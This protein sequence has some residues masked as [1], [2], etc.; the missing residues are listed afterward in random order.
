MRTHSF[1]QAA[2]ISTLLTSGLIQMDGSTARAADNKDF[3]E[4]SSRARLSSAPDSAKSSQ[5]ERY[6]LDHPNR[7]ERKISI[8]SEQME[9]RRQQGR[10]A[11]KAS[12]FRYDDLKTFSGERKGPSVG[13][14]GFSHSRGAM[15]YIEQAM[16]LLR[17][18]F[19][20][21]S[22]T[23]FQSLQSGLSQKISQRKAVL[24]ALDQVRIGFGE[25]VFAFGPNG[26]FEKLMADYRRTKEGSYIVLQQYLLDT[27]NAEG[28]TS[29]PQAIARIILHEISHLFDVG[30]QDDQQSFLFSTRFIHVPD[31]NTALAAT[32]LSVNEDG[33]IDCTL[34]SAPCQI[35]MHDAL[36]V[37][38]P[39]ED[40]PFEE[41]QRI[42]S[43]LAKNIL[44]I[45]A[46]KLDR[47]QGLQI[48]K[49][50]CHRFA[51]TDVCEL[52]TN[53][54]GYVVISANFVDHYTVTFNRWD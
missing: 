16:Q 2:L 25:Q 6:F 23:Q 38:V 27:Y 5:K 3:F 47:A 35:Q 41:N 11:D 7:S 45:A 50:S 51:N 44:Y 46:K 34:S 10:A 37:Q 31:V 39:K 30:L 54:E 29:A 1:F 26:Y 9:L 52:E 48:S 15:V 19:T 8:D 32:G 4:S 22:D 43:R 40:T 28:M 14:G 12:S 53:N 21:M 49:V 20:Q 24:Q 17:T 33:M 13:G 18:L 36:V 42:S